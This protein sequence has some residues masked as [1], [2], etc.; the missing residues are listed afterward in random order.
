M[1]PRQR[2]WWIRHAPT[3]G[4]QGTYIGRQDVSVNLPESSPIELLAGMLPED[5][6]WLTSPLKRC[7]QTAE[8]LI[9]V[10]DETTTPAMIELF[11][12]QNFGAWEGKSYLEVW[13]QYQHHYDWNDPAALLPEDGESFMQVCSRVAPAIDAIIETTSAENIIVVAHAGVIR[14]AI[15]HALKLT[16]A[17]A[18]HLHLDHLSLSC[19]DYYDNPEGWVVRLVNWAPLVGIW[20]P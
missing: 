6:A 2:W 20:R 3:D 10:K 18:L 16:P 14:A 7:V 9:T 17:Q 12:E 11:L 5:A 15:A 8:R 13:Q 19:L 4:E 1:Q